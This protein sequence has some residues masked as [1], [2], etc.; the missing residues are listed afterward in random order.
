MAQPRCPSAG[1]SSVF[2]QCAKPRLT[3]KRN[4][5]KKPQ[6]TAS[7]HRHPQQ[8]SSIACALA[9]CL[10][11]IFC[12]AYCKTFGLGFTANRCYWP[13]TSSNGAMLCPVSRGRA[14]FSGA[15]VLG[16][17]NQGDIQQRPKYRCAHAIRQHAAASRPQI[18]P[19]KSRTIKYP[20]PGCESC[21]LRMLRAATV[22]LQVRSLARSSAKLPS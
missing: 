22:L 9:L 3:Y 15:P 7:H 18:A 14:C 19:L 10:K 11:A 16:R 13:R 8:A 17:T 4:C 12:K 5:K 1:F 2:C 6:Y 21:I 20:H